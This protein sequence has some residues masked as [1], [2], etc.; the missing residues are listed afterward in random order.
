MAAYTL[1]SE[2]QVEY[3]TTRMQEGYKAGCRLIQVVY[4]RTCMQVGCILKCEA[5]VVCRWKCGLE[6]CR[7]GRRKDTQ[8]VGMPYA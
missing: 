3:T 7:P 5:P 6:G 4:T 2:V 1:K 8:E